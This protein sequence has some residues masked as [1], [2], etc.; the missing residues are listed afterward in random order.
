M[1]L[2]N[3]QGFFAALDS[4]SPVAIRPVVDRIFAEEE[5]TEKHTTDESSATIRDSLIN[6]RDMVDVS[7]CTDTNSGQFFYVSLFSRAC[8]VNLVYQC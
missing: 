8:A 4:P 3:S 1:N 6:D 7:D 2:K 5:D